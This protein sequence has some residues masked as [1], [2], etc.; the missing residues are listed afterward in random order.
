V[1]ISFEEALKLHLGLGQILGKLN[2]Y[3][4][5]PVLKSTLLSF[6]VN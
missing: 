3:N 1:I 6:V 2:G 4:R 5:P